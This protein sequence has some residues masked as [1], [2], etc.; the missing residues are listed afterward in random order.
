MILI[1]RY[2]SIVIPKVKHLL[3]AC[4]LLGIMCVLVSC[5]DQEQ[6]DTTDTSKKTIKV[7][8][9]T[10]NI[11]FAAQTANESQIS[12]I[13]ALVFINDGNGY[14][15]SYGATGTS[16]NSD[17]NIST[18]FD[19]VVYTVGQPAKIYIVANANNAI[20]NNLPMVGDTESEVKQKITQSVTS[21]NI[22]D[23]FPMWG[24]YLLP[25]GIASTLNNTVVQLNVLR[26]V[27]R[28]DI[29]TT[30][31]A[32]TFEMVSAQAFRVNNNLQVAPNAYTG[33]LLVSDPSIP[34]GSSATINTAPIII[35]DNISESQLYLPESEAPAVAN[36]VSDATC[37]IVGG[38]YNGSSDITYYRL[39]FAPNIVNY[40]L[41]QI[42]RNHH[43]TFSI[44]NVT[45]P[46]WPTPEEAAENIPTNIE[47]AIQ[48]WADENMNVGMDGTDYFR[49]STRTI[50]LKSPITAYGYASISTDVPVYT[51]QWSDAAGT[52]L[53]TPGE[54]ID[55]GFFRITKSRNIIIV[56]ALTA[57][58]SGTNIEAYFLIVAKRAH[59]LVKVI[60][61][62]S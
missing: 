43:Y 56:D 23:N 1:S 19:I 41:G 36:Q 55:D 27:A 59:I 9:H 16:I 5:S 4:T 40:P 34:T 48:D 53:G 11:T 2:K 7:E 26:A 13:Q 24:E 18:S 62:T 15:Y 35:T 60:Q 45:S 29:S 8:F 44:I 6:D 14:K 54:N 20:A 46:G 49:I 10:K 51:I 61:E 47:V 3:R 37:V 30:E 57:N 42:L 22:T 12:E 31:T 39:D 25:S 17:D 50:T 32:S 58:T 21:A 33:A 38:R 52:P 28:V